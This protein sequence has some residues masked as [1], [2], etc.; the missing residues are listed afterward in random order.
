[1]SSADFLEVASPIENVF[2]MIAFRRPNVRGVINFNCL[3]NQ[4]SGIRVIAGIP[5]ECFWAVLVIRGRLLGNC[6]FAKHAVFLD[7]GCSARRSFTC[8]PCKNKVDD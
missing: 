4:S 3:G 7:A 1:M 2:S 6:I 5:Q 8:I